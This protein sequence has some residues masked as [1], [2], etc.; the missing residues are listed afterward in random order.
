MRREVGRVCV[1]Q[2]DDDY[3]IKECSSFD[4]EER[5]MSRRLVVIVAASPVLI[6]SLWQ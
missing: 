3:D 4:A 1:I 6:I 2:G 5:R